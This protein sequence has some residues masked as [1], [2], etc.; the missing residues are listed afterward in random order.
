[1]NLGSYI[2][3]N[4]VIVFYWQSEIVLVY[5]MFVIILDNFIMLFDKFFYSEDLL[6]MLNQKGCN[7]YWLLFVW[8][9]IVLEMIELGNMV[10]SGII[11]K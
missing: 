10:L 11:L 5:F 8:K 7:C 1:M 6:L 9:N 2:L 4:V 3:L